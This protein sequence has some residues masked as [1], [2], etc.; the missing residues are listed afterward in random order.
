MAK[1]GHLQPRSIYVYLD[2]D[3]SIPSVSAGHDHDRSGSPG[4]TK[5]HGIGQADQDRSSFPGLTK[6][7]GIGQADHD[8]SDC[9]INQTSSQYIARF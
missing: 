6:G 5:G 3:A 4:L 1:V 2:Q 8:T 7:H 9:Q